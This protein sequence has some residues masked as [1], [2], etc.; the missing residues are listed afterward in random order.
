MVA[1]TTGV[2][3]LCSAGVVA[4]W[5]HLLEYVTVR[6][7]VRWFVFENH[8]HLTVQIT[9]PPPPDPR[10]VTFYCVSVCELGTVTMAA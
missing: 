5:H 2:L 7:M 8:W 3:Q 1:A 6:P 10:A 4:H 9:R